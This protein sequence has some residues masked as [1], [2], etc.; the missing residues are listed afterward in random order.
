[1]LYVREVP[2][3]MKKANLKNGPPSYWAI[4]SVT[5]A[6]KAFLTYVDVESPSPPGFGV[7]YGQLQLS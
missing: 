2:E 7:G 6:M 5:R 3:P 4:W 1:M